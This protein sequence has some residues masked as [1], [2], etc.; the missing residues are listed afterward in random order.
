MFIRRLQE[1]EFKSIIDTDQ[2][3]WPV[4]VKKSWTFD[5]PFFEMELS[6]I[7]A[8]VSCYTLMNFYVMLSD[9]Q[10][11]AKILRLKNEILYFIFRIEGAHI[12]L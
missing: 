6:A 7:V 10:N 1:H 9:F 11:N 2:P 3:S 4:H 12:P 5:L 8:P